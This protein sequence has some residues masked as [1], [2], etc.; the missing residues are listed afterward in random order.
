MAGVSGAGAEGSGRKLLIWHNEGRKLTIGQYP[1][2]VYS[3]VND[4]TW[5][6]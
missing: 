3:S 1:R 2:L 4:M 5:F 6:G